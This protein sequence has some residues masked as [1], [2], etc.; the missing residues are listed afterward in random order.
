MKPRC[1]T[2]WTILTLSL[3]LSTTTTSCCNGKTH[4]PTPHLITA[5]PETTSIRTSVPTV[6]EPGLAYGTPCK[7]P[8]WRGLIPGQSTH[9]DVAQ[10]IEQA[11]ADGWAESI[12]DG[13]SVGGGYSISP[14]SFTSHGTIDV[15]M[16]N[17]VVATIGTSTLSFYYPIG[18]LVEQFGAPERLYLVS[19]GATVCSSCEDW[20][21]GKPVPSI[22][23]HLLYPN[24]GLWF[25][26]LI[27]ESGLGCICPEMKV[28]S[29]CY[30]APITLQDAFTDN[31]LAD[32]CSSSLKNV[33]QNDLVEWHGFGG[34]Y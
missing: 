33:A 16:E 27:P 29:F 26:A 19:R 7:P 12:V 3:L 17:D 13:S 30:Y 11:S 5:T 28:T 1:K 25:L 9:Q 23:V 8:C 14:S 31:Y 32:L 15:T 6:V 21:P 34:G 22:P 2:I 20:E 24:Q 18:S 4:T 10:A